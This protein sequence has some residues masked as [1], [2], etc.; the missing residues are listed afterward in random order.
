MPSAVWVL[1]VFVAGAVIGG[2]VVWYIERTRRHIVTTEL[3]R[4][5]TALLETQHDLMQQQLRLQSET[6]RAQSD[7]LMALA[8][9]RF[10]GEQ[11]RI[12]ATLAALVGPIREKIV[13]FDA[14]LKE[15]ESKRIDAYAKLEQKVEHIAQRELEL[16]AVASALQAN[17]GKLVEALRNPG[18]RGRWGEM[19]LRRV[20]ELAGMLEHVD[21]EEQEAVAGGRPDLTV[22]LDDGH[23]V[24]VDAKVPLDD[25]LAA[26]EAA[27]E[28]LRRD[29]F[30]RYAKAIREHVDALAGKE[31]HKRDGAAPFTVLFVPGEAFLSA[32]FIE[33]P[34]LI[35]DAATKGVFVAGPLS[36]L[37]LLKAYAVGWRRRV[38]EEN[39]K[40]IAAQAHELYSRIQTFVGHIQAVGNALRSAVNAF[41]KAVGSYQERVEPAGRRVAEQASFASKE[42]PQLAEIALAPRV[43]ADDG[44]AIQAAD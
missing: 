24:F 41:N 42:L 14:L 39:V 1:L 37:A 32:A 4:A 20:V 35:D 22:H 2:A 3:E 7:Q 17:T 8:S 18:V 13:A 25:Y 34:Q 40:Q 29:C 28:R 6:L 5:R 31:Y 16:Q 44:G 9:E 27:D 23:V 36:L 15:L 12:E 38:Q 11:T 21:F 19:Q 43:F 10:T 26:L 30:K 33:D